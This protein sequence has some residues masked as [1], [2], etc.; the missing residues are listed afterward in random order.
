MKDSPKEASNSEIINESE[1]F[2]STEYEAAE[3]YQ[4]LGFSCVECDYRCEKEM[5][6]KRNTAALS[7]RVKTRFVMKVRKGLQHK[8]IL[9][10]Y[11]TKEH[12]SHKTLQASN[13]KHVKDKCH[14]D[15]CHLFCISKKS[16]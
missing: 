5:T 8:I 4:K 3:D 2:I 9:K 1:T 12:I 14:C 13:N 11:K 10:N 15:E 7:I 6:L 16:I